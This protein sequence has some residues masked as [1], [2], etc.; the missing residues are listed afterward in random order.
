MDATTTTTTSPPA[1]NVVICPW[2]AFGHL[3]PCLDLAERLASRGHRATL[4]STPRNLARLPPVR[5]A[6]AARVGF[7]ALPLPRVAGLPA[8]A[9]S[10]HDVPSESMELLWEAFDGLAAPFAEFLAAACA[11]GGGD[12]PD[13][14][15]FD[16]FHHWAAAAALEHG[17]P[18]VMFQ[19][20]AAYHVAAWSRRLLARELGLLSPR[21]PPPFRP[22]GA[23]RRRRALTTERCTL[24]AMRSCP[25]LEPESAPLAA[26]LRGKPV[27]PLGL[28][29]PA[30]DGGR[31]VDGDHAAVRWLDAQ[32]AGS[33]VYAA[34]GS[35]V[36]LTPAQAHELALGLELA[37]ARFL[38]ALRKPH[39][40]G[41][42]DDDGGVLPPGFRERTRGRGVVTMGWA[43]QISILTHDAIAA[44]LTHCGW[45]SIIEGLLFGRPLIMLPIAWDQWSNARLMEGKMAG[46]QV[47]RDAGGAFGRDGVAAAVR[48]VVVEEESRTIFAANVKKLQDIVSDRERQEEYI[49]GFVQQ[50]RSYKERAELMNGC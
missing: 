35:E 39:G 15:V 12:R 28:M 24:V 20:S 1:L 34:L 50:L 38:W 11:R 19:Q 13:W 43:P 23:R 44:F 10:T 36:P 37:G 46:V 2:L 32:P 26:T 16:I 8:G 40:A 42:E 49:D 45:S 30:L 18:S 14:V 41:D 6:A 21:P 25:E 47:A 5:P 9:E 48:A 27:V 33:V 29:P 7:V 22:H 3:L 31:G 4:V 17:V